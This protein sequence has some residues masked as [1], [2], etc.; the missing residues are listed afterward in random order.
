[1]FIT[2]FKQAQKSLVYLHFKI[3]IQSTIEERRKVHYY[4]WSGDQAEV[5][6]LNP[7]ITDL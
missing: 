3:S 7:W 6:D 1:M 4:S 2:I 5:W